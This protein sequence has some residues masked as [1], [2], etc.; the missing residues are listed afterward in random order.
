M[1]QAINDWFHTIYW[2]AVGGI[3]GSINV[4]LTF[5]LTLIIIRQTN[6]LN[7]QQADLEKKL[8]D[9]NESLTKRQLKMEAFP[10]K[11]ELYLNLFK[12]L[13]FTR[14]IDENLLS[15]DLSKKSLKDLNAIYEITVETYLG[16]VNRIFSS[17]RE[18]EYILPS[19]ISPT[20]QFINIRYNDLC[21]KFI[22]CKTLHNMIPKEKEE[23]VKL[24]MIKGIK[25]DCTFINSKVGFIQS[26]MH[27]ELDIST[28]DD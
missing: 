12:V 27:H 3:F 20:V 25:E 8:N 5:I 13:E 2:D 18:A 19:N 17:L 4:I 21:G 28:I 22:V 11:R 1:L 14:F 16:D 7:A 9:K 10:Y 23:E 26:I 6:K 24:E 15:L